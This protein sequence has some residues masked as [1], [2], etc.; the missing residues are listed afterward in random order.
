M[1]FFN[2]ILAVFPVIK[3]V[4]IA[5][6]PLGFLIFI[7]E[8]GHFLAA[9]RAGIKVNTFSI[10]FGPRIV[11][12]KRGETEY[13]LSW[14]PFGGYVQMEGEDPSEQT[15][16]EGEF[17]SASLGSRAFVVIAGP[18]VNLLFGI[19]AF[20]FIF[21]V[22]IDA[23]SARLMSQ[24]TG[25]SIGEKQ[26]SIQI[27]MIADDGPAD[28]AGVM[29][30]DTI[31]SVNSERITNWAVFHQEI[32]INPGKELELVVE[33]DGNQKTLTATPRAVHDLGPRGESGKLDVLKQDDVIVS[34][35]EEGS[36]A[37]QAG[38]K[39][40]DQID[41]INGHKIY[42]VPH[43][44]TGIWDPKS[45]WL[46]TKYQELYNNID[47]N[48]D[49]LELG[50]LRGSETYTL[51]L[52]VRWQMKANVQKDSP[53]QKAGI[54]TDDI[55]TTFNGKVVDSKSLYDKL[56]AAEGNSVVLGL[57]ST[58]GVEKTVTF[59]LTET[60]KNDAGGT[61]YGLTWDAHVSGMELR[62]PEI[63]MLKYNVFEAF[64][65]GIE[66]TWFT[67]TYIA[68]ILKKLL[69][70]EVKL[71]HLSGPI[72]IVHITSESA[73]GGLTSVLFFI[74]FI[75]IN[76]AIVNLLPIPLADGGHLLFFAIE[77]IRGRPVPR[78]VQEII[79][80]VSFFLLIAFFLYIT[81][82]DS[83]TLFHN[84]RN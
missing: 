38:L 22:G 31:V 69:R 65:K 2:P 68:R 81:W 48:K 11:G 33:R 24:F 42:N 41:T 73:K 70:R 1:E 5:I 51:Q 14:L 36:L 39:V 34:Q 72:G 84:L 28:V 82:F 8:L 75:S 35:I 64:A 19:L 66:T 80:Q 40:G 57:I 43:F 60:S 18:T 74:G 12:F 76:L 23:G 21:T 26:E 29:P 77:K 3:A 37:A 49:S 54:E 6:I 7:H 13:K 78:K 71:N 62:A 32:F 16:A 61:I 53:A 46:G 52:P 55:I 10:G 50:I 58:G 9:K 25:K 79:Q 63:P 47:Q 44:G 17:A 30:G 45:E 20:W 4:L 83:L 27:G 56:K 15:G 67:C 59:S